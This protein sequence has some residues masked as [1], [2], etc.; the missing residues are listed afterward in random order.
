MVVKLSPDRVSNVLS[1]SIYRIIIIAVESDGNTA[2]SFFQVQFFFWRHGMW[3]SLRMLIVKEYNQSIDFSTHL[4][5]CMWCIMHYTAKY[6]ILTVNNVS[7]LVHDSTKSRIIWFWRKFIFFL[8]K[9]PWICK[10]CGRWTWMEPAASKILSLTFC[11]QMK[12]WNLHK[13]NGTLFPFTK[14]NMQRLI[15]T[16]NRLQLFCN[17]SYMS[18]HP[19]GLFIILNQILLRGTLL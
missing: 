6:W 16:L 18:P 14:E 1:N 17:G 8:S 2:I 13:Y 7:K 4:R 12:C 5:V 15:L 9:R 3:I 19:T 10:E 11:P